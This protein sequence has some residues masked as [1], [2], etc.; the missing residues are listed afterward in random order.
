MKI[1]VLYFATLRDRAGDRQETYQ[2]EPGA[3]VLQLQ[4]AAIERHPELEPA[5]EAALIAVNQE[6]AEV[7]QELKDGDEVAFFPPVSG[8]AEEAGPTWLAVTDE[9]LDLNEVLDRLVTDETGAACVFTGVV[10][11][12]T[13]RGDPHDTDHLEY[14]AYREMAEAKLS[15]VADEIRDQWEQIVGVAIIQRLGH[16][17]AGEPTVMIACTAG[18]RDSGVFEAARYGIDRLKEIVPIWKKEVG[19]DGEAWVEGSYRPG[20]E[21][22]RAARD[23]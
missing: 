11:A 17:A 7:E 12:R 15:Q 21:D 16:L 22:R 18:H 9:P 13:E 6:F 2:L 19:P 1:R 23:D 14:E 8:G 5:L 10:R 20:M 4:E 3:R